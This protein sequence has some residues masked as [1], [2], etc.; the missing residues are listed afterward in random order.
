MKAPATRPVQ[1]FPPE[2][3]ARCRSM[4]PVEILEFVENFRLLHH[5]SGVAS[6][7]I[8]MKVPEDLL[9]AFRRRCE[10]AGVPYQTQIKRLMRRWLGAV[11]AG[12]PTAP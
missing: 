2:Y 8:S 5:R 3:L 6:R 4:R 1:Y 10:L 12:E 11:N 7:L 9:D